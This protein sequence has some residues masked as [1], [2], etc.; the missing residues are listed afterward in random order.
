[1]PRF[2]L[3]NMLGQVEHVLCDLDVLDVVK[4]FGGVAHLVGIAEQHT[5]QPLVAG[6]QRNDV[7]TVG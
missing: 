4:I 2:G 7:L 6:F 1:M 3:D 5:H